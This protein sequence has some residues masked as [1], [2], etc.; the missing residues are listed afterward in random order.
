[1]EVECNRREH[2]EGSV[3]ER[4]VTSADEGDDTSHSSHCHDD[5]IRDD[6]LSSDSQ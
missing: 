2:E 6:P 3:M 4:M 5:D 1:M